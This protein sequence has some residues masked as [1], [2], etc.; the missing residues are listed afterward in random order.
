MQC[1]QEVKNCHK[2]VSG[3]FLRKRTR[4]L[5]LLL[6]DPCNGLFSRILLEHE[7]MG[8]QWHQLDHMQIICTS[9]QSDNHA[10]TSQKELQ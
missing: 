10:S 3:F 9:L 8:W 1:Q 5:L 2:K 6:L 7:I 4:V